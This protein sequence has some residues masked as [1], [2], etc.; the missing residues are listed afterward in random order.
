MGCVDALGMLVHI[1]LLASVATTAPAPDP[2]ASDVCVK[3]RD[4]DDASGV[5]L[6]EVPS[7]S[8]VTCSPA[9]LE[10]EDVSSRSFTPHP[11]AVLLGGTATE[12]T[13]PAAAEIRI[14]APD[15]PG[16]RPKI[17]LT[18]ASSSDPSASSTRAH[19]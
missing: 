13:P 16:R 19:G 7:T 12:H 11:A 8:T 17:E 4:E 6:H 14:A 2:D 15:V 1:D 9:L 5:R 3:L 18:G 10:L